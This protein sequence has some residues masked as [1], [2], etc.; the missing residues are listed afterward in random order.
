MGDYNSLRVSSYFQSELVNEYSEYEIL[1][2][3]SEMLN[4]TTYFV[5]LLL[6]TCYL[7]SRIFNSHIVS[8]FSK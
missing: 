4:I 2:M 8:I 3:K 6:L 5:L 7:T 1:K